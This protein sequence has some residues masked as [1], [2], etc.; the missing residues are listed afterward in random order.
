MYYK[1]SY[2]IF[3][4]LPEE[5]KQIDFDAIHT[6]YKNVKDIDGVHIDWKAASKDHIVRLHV[7]SNVAGVQE[8]MVDIMELLNGMGYR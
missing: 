2:R 3:D 1:E 5:G 6:V 4:V 8:I 7:A